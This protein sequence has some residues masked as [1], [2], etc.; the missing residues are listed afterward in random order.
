MAGRSHTRAP[1]LRRMTLLALGALALGSYAFA[2]A[3]T[4][5]A[6][7][8]NP[9][10]GHMIT[11]AGARL[12]TLQRGS[13]PDV[14]LI[15]GAAMM[16]RE[17]MANASADA[18]AR[19]YRLTAFDRPGHGWSS[20]RRQPSIFDQ[21]EIIRDAVHALK[22]TRPV[23]V[24]HS[25]GGAVALAYGAL[26]PEETAGVV[27]LAPMAYPGWGPAH[28]GRAVRATPG[29]GPFLSNTVLALTDPPMM[30]AAV[31]L[32]FSPQTPTPQFE[33]EVP[34]EMLSR[35]SAMAADA[36]D[37]IAASRDLEHLSRDYGGYPLPVEIVVGSEDRV[38]DHARQ[39]ERLAR[40][41]PDARLA[42]L[43][44]LGHMVHHFAPDAVTAAVDAIG[45]RDDARA[46]A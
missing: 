33:A 13:G 10:E 7:A 29:L 8:R 16:A 40:D 9:W 28:L 15:H 23:V 39:G 34:R 43:E 19:R 5:A 4:R 18:L 37:F 25:L 6:L 21:A 20:E 32:I 24:G 22:L 36:A 17:M 26:F 46:A 1:D 12:H 44:G 30:R 11:V 35:P 31:R 27:A 45:G 38:L 3:R 42:R 14:V 41:L 2:R